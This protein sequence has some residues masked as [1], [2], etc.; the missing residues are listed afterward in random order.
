VAL[1]Q[2]GQQDVA[3]RAAEQRHGAEQQEGPGELTSARP[4]RPAVMSASAP[5]TAR[6][7]PSREAIAGAYQPDEREADDRQRGQDTGERAAQPD[8][9][10]HLAQQ[11]ADARDGRAQVERGEHDRRD[12]RPAG[13]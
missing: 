8:P 3:D 4:S 1:D 9:V 6:C 10:L 2:R 7:S 11:R 13:R 5:V 12:Q